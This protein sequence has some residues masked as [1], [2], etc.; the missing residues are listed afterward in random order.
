MYNSITNRR[1][2]GI[3]FLSPLLSSSSA[4]CHRAKQTSSSSFL[5]SSCFFCPLRSTAQIYKAIHA[6]LH[7][8]DLWS[9]QR[10]A[11]TERRGSGGEG[12]RMCIH[13]LNELVFV[14][15][16]HVFSCFCALGC[17]CSCP[18][19]LVAHS[20]PSPAALRMLRRRR[21]GERVRRIDCHCPFTQEEERK[22]QKAKAGAS[23]EWGTKRATEERGEEGA[24]RRKEEARR[25][26]DDA[27][28]ASAVLQLQLER[29]PAMKTPLC[30][31]CCCPCCRRC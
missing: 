19:P 14:V 15:S 22:E 3:F 10:A 5:S 18:T 24:W 27:L 29:V 13:K 23:E 30:C 8:R 25:R 11:R 28:T 16:N 31:C 9:S 1:A 2:A 20:P 17:R 7:S 26:G 21:M 12:F 6:F 4:V